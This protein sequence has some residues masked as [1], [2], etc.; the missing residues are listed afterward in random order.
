VVKA[1]QSPFKM[2]LATRLLVLATLAQGLE[3]SL[4]PILWLPLGD[5]ITLGCGSL[6]KP[7]DRDYAHCSPFAAGYRVPLAYALTQQGF[8][9]STMGTQTNGPAAWVSPQWLHHEGHPGLTIANLLTNGQLNKSFAHPSAN[10]KLPGLITVH[11]GTNDCAV[12]FKHGRHGPLTRNYPPQIAKEAEKLL[13]VL[14]ER[15][16][17]AR[18]F[19]ASLIHFPKEHDCVAGYNALLPK[20]V[21]DHRSRGMQ[22]FYVPLS[23]SV[24][25]CA[26]NSTDEEPRMSGLCL[27]DETHPTAAGYLHIAGAFALAIAEAF[28]GS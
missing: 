2:I 7:R 9:V 16:P 21:A 8:D 27:R 4:E 1:L 10:G 12:R 11:M 15:A 25:L 13:A 18:V 3:P 24:K 14:Y 6:E 22:V 20:V 19:I 17:K 28:S 23:E 5:S 26:S